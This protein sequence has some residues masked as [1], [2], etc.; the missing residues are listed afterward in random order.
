MKKMQKAHK[1][2]WYDVFLNGKEI[3]SIPYSSELT[4]EEVK[5]SLVQHDGYDPE[6]EVKRHSL[7]GTT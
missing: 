5:K 2:F 6:I 3:D 4:E 1:L 7:L